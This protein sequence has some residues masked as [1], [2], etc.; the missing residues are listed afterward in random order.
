MMMMMMMMMIGDITNWIRAKWGYAFETNF[1]N[2]AHLIG[3][4][5]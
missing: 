1:K 5:E 4:N 3:S 2:I